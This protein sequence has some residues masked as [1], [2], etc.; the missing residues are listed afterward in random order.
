M[1]ETT[2]CV[3]HPNLLAAGWQNVRGEDGEL[4]RTLLCLDCLMEHGGEVPEGS[5]VPMSGGKPCKCGPGFCASDLGIGY[6]GFCHPSSRAARKAA[7]DC[8]ACG[9]PHQGTDGC[10]LCNGNP[11][12]LLNTAG[13]LLALHLG[14]AGHDAI[15]AQEEARVS[16]EGHLSFEDAVRRVAAAQERERS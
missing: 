3:W 12:G 11:E 15:D 16:G 4:H 1:T 6:Y 9:A 14:V 7:P 13:W 8:P 5:L 10:W 2:A